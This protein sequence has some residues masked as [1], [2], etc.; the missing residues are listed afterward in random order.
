[1]LFNLDGVEIQ[2]IPRTRSR[3]FA[4]W[5]QNLSPT[6]YQAVTDAINQYADTRDVF[7][8]S[9][10]PGKDWTGTVYEPLYHA[11]RLDQQHAAYFFG[12]IV[13]KTRIGRE[14]VWYFK[15]SDRD[16]DDVMGMTYFRKR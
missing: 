13:W 8:S 2:D 7:V 1:M 5:V 11:C 16:G 14:D 9:H 15:P 6:D 3:D 4:A 10:I 12:L